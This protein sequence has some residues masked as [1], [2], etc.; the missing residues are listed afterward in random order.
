MWI[1]S[2]ALMVNT[3]NIVALNI[4]KNSDKDLNVSGNWIVCTVY[5]LQAMTNDGHTFILTPYC[6]KSSTVA[7]VLTEIFQALKTDQ[8]FYVVNV[9]EDEKTKEAVI[10]KQL[11]RIETESRATN[12]L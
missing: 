9:H 5:Y 8:K 11:A 7:Q 1:K 3:D 2:G 12:S 10:E 6:F 4:R